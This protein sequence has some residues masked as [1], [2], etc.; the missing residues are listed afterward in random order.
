MTPADSLRFIGPSDTSS[1]QPSPCRCTCHAGAGRLSLTQHPPWS[2]LV[3]TPCRECVMSAAWLMLAVRHAA[4]HAAQ[5]GHRCRERERRARAECKA[6]GKIKGRGTSWRGKFVCTWE[7]R[8][9]REGMAVCRKDAPSRVRIEK[10][11]CFTR[12]VALI[13][14][15][16]TP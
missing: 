16:A 10:N 2:S 1:R 12:C 4:R 6:E 14:E 8:G 5:P 7:W 9:T 15:G 11:A 13:L 3:Q